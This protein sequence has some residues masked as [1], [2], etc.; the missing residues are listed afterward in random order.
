MLCDG[1]SGFHQIGARWTFFT[2]F[3]LTPT[4]PLGERENRLPLRVAIPSLDR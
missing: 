1:R 4:L 3:T 2:A